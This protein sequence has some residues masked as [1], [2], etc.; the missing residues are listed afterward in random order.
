MCYLLCFSFV[1][2]VLDLCYFL[3]FIVI[4]LND[5]ILN[6]V[7]CVFLVIFCGSGWV[8]LLIVLSIL[9]LRFKVLGKFV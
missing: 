9:I 3:K 4:V 2:I 5:C 8:R 1:G 7:F 6:F